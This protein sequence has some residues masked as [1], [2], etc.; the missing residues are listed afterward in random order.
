[1]TMGELM[2]VQLLDVLNVTYLTSFIW[3]WV[4]I[5]INRIHCSIRVG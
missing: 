2:V 4:S 3:P 1:M 5:D